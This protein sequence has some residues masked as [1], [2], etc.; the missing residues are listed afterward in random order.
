MLTE[1]PFLGEIFLIRI[2]CQYSFPRFRS[3]NNRL[4][5]EG[6]HHLQTQDCC[7]GGG[8]SL[9][10]AAPVTEEAPLWPITPTHCFNL[11]ISPQLSEHQSWA[12]DRWCFVGVFR[13]PLGT[14]G[15]HMSSNHLET[16]TQPCS[17]SLSTSLTCV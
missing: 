6:L 14:M 5:M 7:C 11:L 2:H 10:S 13:L 17:K 16:T 1:F 4:F 12:P 9:Q 3:A 15:L 8:G